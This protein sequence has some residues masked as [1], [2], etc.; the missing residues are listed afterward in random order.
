MFHPDSMLKIGHDREAELIRDAD[1]CGVAQA[2]Q[3]GRRLGGPAIRTLSLAAT[4][5]TMVVGLAYLLGH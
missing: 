1:A 3:A 4:L 2:S 5:V